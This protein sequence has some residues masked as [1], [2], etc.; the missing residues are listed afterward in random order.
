MGLRRTGAGAAGIAALGVL[1]GVAAGQAPN[2]PVFL[3]TFEVYPPGVFPCA[4][5]GCTGEGG[6]GVWFYEYG[7][8]PYPGQ[9]ITSAG[10]S[11]TRSV[12]MAPFTD[13]VRRC[14]FISGVWDIR[15]W[16]WFPVNAT[17]PSDAA[18]FILFNESDGVAP[19]G[20]AQIILFEGASGTVKNTWHPEENLP[21]AR[22]RWAELRLR[23]DI[24]QNTVS[25][26]YDGHP[27][28]A[29]EPYRSD[30]PVAIQCINWYSDGIDGMLFD[31][32]S[33]IPAPGSCYPNCDD[34]TTPPVLNVLD[35][36]CYMNR[37]VSGCP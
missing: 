8:G 34:S 23:V 18:D 37:F 32:V 3:D 10:H 20:F 36:N 6:W 7:N 30:G 26:W 12:R 15:T 31:D 14:N 9:L 5:T 11:G 1:A 28:F 16:T 24:G 4:E 19:E 35:F 27:L 13:I 17:A 29:G 25:A 2:T 22:G 21:L 33:I